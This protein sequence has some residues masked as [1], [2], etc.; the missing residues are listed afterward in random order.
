MTEGSR[1]LERSANHRKGRD[2]NRFAP[3]RACQMRL[4]PPSG[5]KT[6]L[7]VIREPAVS[8]AL[9]QRRLLSGNPLGCGN[10]TGSTVQSFE[11]DD[12]R[13]H[14]HFQSGQALITIAN[15]HYPV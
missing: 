5:C 6:R 10:A 1:W 4:A 12:S 15:W 13:G 7:F 8:A 9:R 3:R 2:I 11:E 14:P